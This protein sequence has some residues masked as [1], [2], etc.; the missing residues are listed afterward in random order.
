VNEHRKA[1]SQPPVSKASPGSVFWR[2]LIPFTIVAASL[3]FGNIV[4]AQD[5]GG[6]S[7]MFVP[8][9]SASGDAQIVLN[10]GTYLLRANHSQEAIAKF[11]EAVRI[12]PGFA[13]PHHQWGIALVKLGKPDEAVA[14]FK[15]AIQLNPQLAASWL[16]LGGAYQSAGDTKD[17]IQAYSDFLTRFPSDRDAAKIR[18]L[19][20]MLQRENGDAAGAGNSI[21]SR[22]RA[23]VVDGS[24]QPLSKAAGP[25]G[26]T[27]TGAGA[28]NAD[29]AKPSATSDSGAGDY[30]NEVTKSGV[31]KWSATRM[32]LRVFVEDGK[33]V[34][35]YR[36]V[37]ST[38]LKEAFNDWANGS[39][40]L[41]S[42]VIVADSQHASVV[43]R[44]FN[45][46]DKF[47]NG[48]ECAET[49]LYSDRNGVARGEVDLLTV[50]TAPSL[51]LT[52]NR[53]RA[54]ALHEVGH[55]LGLTGHTSDPKDIMFYSASMSDS[56][57]DLTGRDK[58]TLTR[59]YRNN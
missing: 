31:I 21:P 11:Q 17:A 51:P 28:L 4:F 32:P 10:Q 9:D 57:R 22:A 23:P 38:I 43:C 1:D 41:V 56:W 47:Q 27:A 35:G 12:S 52:D 19:I 39:D 29:R 46:P 36:P 15:T 50:S 3:L 18:K 34:P 40:G 45:Q 5:G 30:L 59:L 49:R 42:V 2:S 6:D 7:P 33:G 25:A 14:Q 44:W 54:V 55:V 13:D 8:S 24:V 58:R 53:F 37:F 48:T 26:M 16:S 20:T